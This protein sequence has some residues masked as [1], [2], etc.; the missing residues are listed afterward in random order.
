M[1]SFKCEGENGYDKLESIKVFSLLRLYVK[2]GG[3]E[4]IRLRENLL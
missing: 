4:D 3:E 2:Y 1:G